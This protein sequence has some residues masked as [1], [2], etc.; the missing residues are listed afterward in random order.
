MAGLTDRDRAFA[1]DLKYPLPV[2]KWL[3]ISLDVIDT[4]YFTGDFNNGMHLWITSDY[5]SG[6]PD[7]EFRN[8]VNLDLSRV[9]SNAPFSFEFKI[10]TPAT[11]EFQIYFRGKSFI[12]DNFK[13][14]I[15]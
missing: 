15:I 12:V 2:G 10:N 6:I 4:Q 3:K 5:L 14:E 13:L 9:V 8:R 11:Y 7:I 1:M